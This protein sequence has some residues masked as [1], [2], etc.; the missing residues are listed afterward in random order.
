MANSRISLLW[1]VPLF[2]LLFVS[3]WVGANASWQAGSVYAIM[4][5]LVIIVVVLWKPIT[6]AIKK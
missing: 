4:C 5:L 3:L 2:L 1:L 6:D